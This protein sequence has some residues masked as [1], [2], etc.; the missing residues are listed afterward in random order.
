M[1]PVEICAAASK[2]SIP[3]FYYLL[4][5][6]QENNLDAACRTS[7]DVLGSSVPLSSESLPLT[8]H[9]S[10]PQACISAPRQ[11]H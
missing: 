4:H 1:V 10:Q 8:P 2:W 6:G 9:G 5:D 7:E 11:A 3:Y